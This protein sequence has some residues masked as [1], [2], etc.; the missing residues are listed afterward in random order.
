MRN[1]VLFSWVR[2][3]AKRNSHTWAH[4]PKAS[5]GLCTL[6]ENLWTHGFLEHQGVFKD[7]LN[8]LYGLNVEVKKKKKA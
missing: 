4:H 7:S 6:G 3:K 2:T 1:E 8:H 5:L